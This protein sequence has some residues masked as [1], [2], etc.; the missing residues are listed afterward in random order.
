[1]GTR[2][3]T[4]AGPF[5]LGEKA[6]ITHGGAGGWRAASNLEDVINAVQSAAREAL[7]EN[8]LEGMLVK[9]I[10]VL[11]D[12][13]VLNAGLGSVLSID[14]KLT[15]DAGLMY[16][17]LRAGGVAAVTYPRNPI[18]LADWV[19]RN[20]YHVLLAGPE[21]DKLAEKLGLKRHPGPSERALKRWKELLEQVKNG[22]GPEWARKMASLLFADTVGAVVL[23][24]GRLG[25]GTSTGG[26]AL[27]HPARVGDSPIP[28]AG[29]YVEKGVGGC[30]A[31]GIGE[32]IIL[33]RP[34]V[35][36]V[37]LLKQGLP[38]EEAARAAVAR[39]TALFG[40]DNLGIILLN[41]EGY[42]AAAMN[43]AG[44]PVGIAGNKHEAKGFMLL[45]REE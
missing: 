13:G 20:L 3:E 35:Y 9:A 30:A 29:F 10:V 34:C 12:S 39:H 26:V 21:A 42:A 32:T 11:E 2:A 8:S 37:E 7:S 6:V 43:T 45:R 1:M 36:A 5:Y 31:T 23:Y 4:Y 14:G 16:D 22:K 44:M 27:K 41:A 18:R 25:A 40:S 38:V 33:G 19:A 28:G 24:N 15:M 17:D